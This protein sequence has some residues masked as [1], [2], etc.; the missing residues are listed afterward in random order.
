MARFTPVRI[1]FDDGREAT[2]QTSSRDMLAIEKAGVQL[3]ELGPVES[4]YVIAHHTLTRYKR[5]GLVEFDVPDTAEELS[6]VADLDYVD[7][8]AEGK[9]SAPVPST[10]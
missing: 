1:V 3:A 9:G 8:D 6:E 7:E 2:V 5:Q 10:G 4:S